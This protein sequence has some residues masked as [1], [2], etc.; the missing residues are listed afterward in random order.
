VDVMIWVLVG[1]GVVV[2]GV[3][4][5][6]FLRSREKGEEPYL[7]FRCQGCRRRLRFH[8]RQAG[9]AGECSHCGRKMTFPTASES[10]D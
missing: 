7:H 10:L 5:Y 8:A 3:V 1:A 2:L 6:R 9:H 4:G